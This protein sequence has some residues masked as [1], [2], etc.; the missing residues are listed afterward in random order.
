MFAS[1]VFSLF[2]LDL[3]ATLYTSCIPY[4]I[5]NTFS[6]S[7]KKK[8]VGK[9]Q[10]KKKKS[11]KRLIKVLAQANLSMKFKKDEHPFPINPYTIQ[12]EI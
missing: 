6:L 11:P 1:F 12:M 7:I 2:F 9:T 8:N 3:V 5:Y 4:F 10:P